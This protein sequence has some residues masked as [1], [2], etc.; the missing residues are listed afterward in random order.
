MI[1]TEIYANRSVEE[2]IFEEIEKRIPGF[3]YS[4]IEDVKG[5]GNCGV[6][7]G[8]AIWPELNI[9]Y[10][11]FGSRHDASLIDEAVSEVKKVFAREGIKIFQY[12][13]NASLEER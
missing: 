13:V 7:H 6:R 1:R 8:T 3:S 4:L 12:E 11:H 5:R 2:D 10:I 9:L